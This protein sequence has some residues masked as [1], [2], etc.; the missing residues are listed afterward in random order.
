[1][2][3]CCCGHDPTTLQPQVLN[4]NNNLNKTQKEKKIDTFRLGNVLFSQPDS[5]ILHSKFSKYKFI[6]NKNNDC[7]L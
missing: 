6:K 4:A 3:V 5:Q 1:M 7:M 2:I